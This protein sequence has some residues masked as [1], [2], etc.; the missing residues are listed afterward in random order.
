MGKLGDLLEML[1]SYCSK[2]YYI[3]DDGWNGETRIDED[4]KHIVDI[5][6]RLRMM[7]NNYLHADAK[8]YEP[9]SPD[10]LV[11]CINYIC[12]EMEGK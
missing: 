12:D 2:F 5:L 4:D 11:E 8:E 6:Q 1:K 7:R 3:Y 10:E 9:L